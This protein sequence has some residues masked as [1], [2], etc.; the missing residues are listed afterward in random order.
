MCRLRCAQAIRDE[1]RPIAGNLVG[2]DDFKAQV[3]AVFENLR[4]ALDSQGRG[5]SDVVRFTTYLVH[6]QDIATFHEVRTELF[7]TIISGR[8]FPPNT[9][10]VIDRLVSKE[11]WGAFIDHAPHLGLR[12]LLT[13]G[14]ID[15]QTVGSNTR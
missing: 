10:L 11:L 8:G 6:S 5:F 9:L 12:L 2:R 14:R 3:E 13:L 1:Y 15:I 7:Q 4:L